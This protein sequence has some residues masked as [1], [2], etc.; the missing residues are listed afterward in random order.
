MRLPLLVLASSIL[1]HA[2]V[3]CSGSD[4]SIAPE[5]PVTPGDA[6]ATFC[7]GIG[8]VR[9]HFV[10]QSGNGYDATLTAVTR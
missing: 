8:P 7:R 1:V 4:S 10:E 6:Y 5:T 2:R 9:W 3:G